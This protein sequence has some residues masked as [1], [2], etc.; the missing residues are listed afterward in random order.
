MSCPSK[1]G[2]KGYDNTQCALEG[3]SE[4]V[5]IVCNHIVIDADDGGGISIG[6]EKIVESLTEVLKVDNGQVVVLD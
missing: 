1:Y 2:G 3:I 4:A 5:A 6:K